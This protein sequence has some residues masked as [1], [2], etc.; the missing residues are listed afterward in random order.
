MSTTKSAKNRGR[1]W[2]KVQ[3]APPHRRGRRP[4]RPEPFRSGY[5]RAVVDASPYGGTRTSNTHEG[6]RCSSLQRMRTAGCRPYVGT[7]TAGCRPYVGT[8]TAGCRPYGE[9]RTAGCRPYGGCGRQGAV[10][11]WGRGRQG[12]LRP[13]S[14][15]QCAPR[16]NAPRADGMF[17]CSIL[18]FIPC[19]MKNT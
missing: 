16:C 4:R 10:P 12:A 1:F 15:A 7:R 2:Q 11:T 6:H 5:V 9:T 19:S 14:G 17:H 18:C 13:G 8:R 3:N